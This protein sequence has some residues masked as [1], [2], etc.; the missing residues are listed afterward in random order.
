[1]ASWITFDCFGTLVDWNAGFASILAPLAGDKTPALLSA[2]HRFERQVEAER[3]H[4]LYKDVLTTSLVRA[5]HEVGVPMSEKQA[6]TLPASWDRLPVFGDVEPML[7]ALRAA[8]YKLA[9]LTNCDDDLFAQ[10]QG[11]FV[12]PFDMVVTAEQV[13]DYKPSLT[14]FR[15]FED[16]ASPDDWIHVASSWHHDIAPARRFG[17]KRIWLDRDKAGPSEPLDEGASGATARI[18]SASEVLAAIAGIASTS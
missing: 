15:R 3:P 18:E 10:T 4:R 1:M 9:V 7:A 5:A 16:L 13:R 6:G 17:I 8:G 12:R 14:H 11:M 2:Y